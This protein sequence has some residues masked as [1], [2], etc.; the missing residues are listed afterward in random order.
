MK[1]VINFKG[2]IKFDTT[3]PDGTY[4]KLL[5]ST[6]IN[7]LK[8]KQEINFKEGLSKT[9]KYFLKKFNNG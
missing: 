8:F 5:D 9:Y 1:D 4:R 7:S 2:D 6:K 3:K